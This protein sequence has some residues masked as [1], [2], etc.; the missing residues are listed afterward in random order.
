[1]TFS[2]TISLNDENKTDDISQGFR[3]LEYAF[4]DNVRLMFDALQATAEFFMA[5][6]PTSF[7]RTLDSAAARA[8]FEAIEESRITFTPKL[9]LE[10]HYKRW[11]YLFI[12]ALM[13]QKPRREF[14]QERYSYEFPGAEGEKRWVLHPEVSQEY[15][16][17]VFAHP[18]GPSSKMRPCLLAAIRALQY[19]RYSG[20]NAIDRHELAVF[21]ETRFGYQKEIVEVILN[22]MLEAGVLAHYVDE[23]EASRAHLELTGRGEFIL[24]RLVNSLEYINLALQTAPLPRLLVRKDL[25]PVRPYSSESYVTDN[26]IVSTINF[27]RL[28]SDVEDCERDHFNRRVKEEH[29]ERE[30]NASFD[31]YGD[32]GLAVT[33][34]MKDN[35]KA[36]MTRIISDAYR[37]KDARL[38]GQLRDRLLE[39]PEQFFPTVDSFGS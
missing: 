12:E 22:Q 2:I 27:L 24:D 30:P 7:D 5:H 28:L 4:G 38:I 6:L 16:Y 35:V 10:K 14:R 8:E 17:N 3:L 34:R 39:Q 36:A 19:A 33:G 1:V 37:R 9:S 26:K 23:P 29:R 18:S 20:T 15:L 11:Y 21:L 25:F 13:L 31:A 32:G